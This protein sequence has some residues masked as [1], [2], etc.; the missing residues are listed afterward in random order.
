MALI[1]YNGL[2]DQNYDQ[3]YFLLNVFT[4]SKVSY[5]CISL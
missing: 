4:A 1:L 2:A 3:D 5:F